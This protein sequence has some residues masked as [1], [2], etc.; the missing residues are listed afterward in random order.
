M[1]QHDNTNCSA[2]S[3]TQVWKIL[4]QL[5]TIGLVKYVKGETENPMF[6]MQL[7]V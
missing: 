4:H 7:Q 3:V 6:L 2:K 5:H 1:T